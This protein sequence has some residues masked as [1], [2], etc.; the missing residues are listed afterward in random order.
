[1]GARRSC[2]HA[3]KPPKIKRSKC[4]QNPS[5]PKSKRR[6]TPSPSPNKGQSSKTQHDISCLRHTLNK[7]ALSTTP[8][9]V[10]PLEL[11]TSTNPAFVP[12]LSRPTDGS[13][14]SRMQMERHVLPFAQATTTSHSPTPLPWSVESQRSQRPFPPQ[15]YL[16]PQPLDLFPGVSLPGT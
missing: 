12:W 4:L 9:A 8:F 2:E 13:P 10:R 3:L 6:R 7:C 16:T 5:L 15:H 11:S 14:S 1:M